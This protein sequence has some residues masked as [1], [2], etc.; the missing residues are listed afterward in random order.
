MILKRQLIGLTISMIIGYIGIMYIYAAR[1][2]ENPITTL[3]IG[4][5]LCAISF[6]GLF[7]SKDIK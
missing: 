2:S 4:V 6:I 5:I 7:T 1:I 3:L